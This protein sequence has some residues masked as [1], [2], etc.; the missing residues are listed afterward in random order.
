MTQFSKDI[1]AG[2]VELNDD[3]LGAVCGGRNADFQIQYV[4]SDQQNADGVARSGRHL[5][6]CES[7]LFMSNNIA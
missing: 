4:M 1:A 2:I 3:A 7:K 6:D 5:G